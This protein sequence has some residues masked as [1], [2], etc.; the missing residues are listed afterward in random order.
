MVTVSGAEAVTTPIPEGVVPLPLIVTVEVPWAALV[1]AKPFGP[2]HEVKVENPMP[3]PTSKTSPHVPPRTMNRRRRRASKPKAT[4]P[5]NRKPLN[6]KVV[7]L[8]ETDPTTVPADALMVIVPCAGF[9]LPSGFWLPGN[10]YV[11]GLT[12]HVTLAGTSPQPNVTVP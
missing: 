7:K 4:A 2:P 5:G 1:L 6:C 10:E 11:D 3:I 9:S 8:R 12:T